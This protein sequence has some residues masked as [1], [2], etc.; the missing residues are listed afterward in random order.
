MSHF[1]KSGGGPLWRSAIGF[2]GCFGAACGGLAAAEFAI[3][4]P[5]MISMYFGVT[6]LSDGYTASTKVTTVASTAADLVAQ[7]S[8]VCNAEMNDV[9]A[10]L[11][12]IMFPYALNNMQIVVSSLIDGGNG[13]VKV[14]WSD[15]QNTSPRTVNSVVSVPAGLVA[16][17][18]SV[19]L[20]EVSYSYSSPTGHLIYGSVPLGD[21]FYL[22]PRRVAQI[23]R[24]VS[25]C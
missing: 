3:M 23:N 14:A 15:A 2:L 10:A 17:G 19:I 8:T 22:H 16:V 4:A 9:F 12:T 25:V 21:K 5:V 7:E 24:T 6:E 18:G 1:E 13:T 20:A 11:N